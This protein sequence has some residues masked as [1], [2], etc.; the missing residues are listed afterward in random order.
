MQEGCYIYKKEVDW[1]LLNQ[2]MSIPVNIQ[3]VFYAS[4]SH[5]I[6][7]GEEKPIKLVIEGKTYSAA[8][9]NQKFDPRKFAGHKDVL[10][11]RY[12][13][14]SAIA[15]KLREIFSSTYHY[16]LGL[17]EQKGEKKTYIKIP[18][19]LKEFMAVYTTIYEDTYLAECI[20][21]N[22]LKKAREFFINEHED[23]YE[24]TQNYNITDPSASID[25][26]QRTA[27]I[28]KLNK[29]IGDNLKILY[30]NECQICGT[31]FGRK[32]DA[33]IVECHH[34][35]PFVKS[36]NNDSLN[37]I[38]IC[39]NHHRVIHK[40]NPVFDRKKMIWTY[41]NGTIEQ[42]KLNRHLA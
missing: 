41:E 20:T 40:V 17:R 2:G 7:R 34:I 39:P 27:K 16:V 5:Y 3:V 15:E 38:V 26:I 4:I 12:N 10:Q 35:D 28:R 1:S 8:L 13:P 30:N 32:Y 37:Q 25:V 31:D 14:T 22:E 19:H 33:K 21:V 23:Q 29:A 9:I 24:A 11:I 42:I 6:N 36:F 18:E